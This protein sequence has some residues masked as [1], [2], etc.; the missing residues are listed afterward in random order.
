MWVV[1]KVVKRA[2]PMVVSSDEK[3]ASFLAD[4]TVEWMVALTVEM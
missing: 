4:E 1:P 2:A 3:K